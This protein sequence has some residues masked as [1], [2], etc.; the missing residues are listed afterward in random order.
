[1]LRSDDYD[2]RRLPQRIE[3]IAEDAEVKGA[4]LRGTDCSYQPVDQGGRGFVEFNEDGVEGVDSL[5]LG[6]AEVLVDGLVELPAWLCRVERVL[7]K[8]QIEQLQQRCIECAYCAS[9]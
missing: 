8:K 4:Y 5:V 2:W 7:E 6:D 3:I 1:M 9:H